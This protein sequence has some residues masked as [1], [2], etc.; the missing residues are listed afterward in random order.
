MTAA[1]EK[2]SISG[3]QLA[4]ARSRARLTQR[5]LGALLKHSERAAQASLAV[6]WHRA[7]SPW[8]DPFSA[9]TSGK[10][11]RTLSQFSNM[12]L[13]AELAKRLDAAGSDRNY[14]ETES[15]SA[16]K[17]DVPTVKQRSVVSV[18]THARG[19]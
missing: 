1:T 16:T 2:M 12:A 10:A 7:R 5:E 9:A 3:S 15:V 13:L 17:P 19:R 14:A 8:S 6:A 4:A 18:S 11:P